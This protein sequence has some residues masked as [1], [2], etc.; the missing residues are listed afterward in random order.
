MT[1]PFVNTHLLKNRFEPRPF[2]KCVFHFDGADWLDD[3][4]VRSGIIVARD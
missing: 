4:L 2:R 3:F 1:A